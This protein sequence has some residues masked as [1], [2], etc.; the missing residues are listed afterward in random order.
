VPHSH[1]ALGA[2]HA[3][4]EGDQRLQHVVLAV[5]AAGAR[6]AHAGQVGVDPPQVLACGEDRLVGSGLEAAVHRP[7]VQEED[8]VACAYSS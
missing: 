4:D 7:A 5:D 6:A 3:V 2:E 1:E 8:C